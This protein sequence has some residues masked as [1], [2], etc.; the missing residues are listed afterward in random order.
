M[1]KIASMRYFKTTCIVIA[2]IAA[3]AFFALQKEEYS[4]RADGR[5]KTVA[6]YRWQTIP[7]I[8]KAA[9]FTVGEGDAFILP[10]G[11][12]VELARAVD[13]VVFADGGRQVIRTGQA[14]LEKALAKAGVRLRGREIFPSGGAKPADGMNVVLLRSNEKIL[15]D[16]Q[17]I[18]YKV[19][20]KY[21]DRMELGEK[22]VLKAGV[23]GKKKILTKITAR[24]GGG[25][26]K[27]VLA[28]T[29]VEIPQEQL[30][31][32]GDANIVQT[33]RGQLRFIKTLDMEATAYTPWDEGCTGI[34]KTGIPARYGV[35][36]VDPGVIKLGTR[37]YVA[38]YGQAIAA[39]IGG[40]IVGNRIDLCM[41]STA[42]A[43]KFGRRRVKVYIL[44]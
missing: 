20:E 7:D 2:S 6:V 24:P 26:E 27:E 33:S 31:A 36:A 18:P 1:Q 22:A 19:V 13:I 25:T 17:Q 32:V 5:E 9:G 12:V 30:V 16:V 10:K 14:T 29:I 28:E 44:E 42:Q 37:L 8:I 23:N 41:E 40:A 4:V 34:T 43:I 21:D 38:G 11:N 39:D 3:A 35:A 15:E